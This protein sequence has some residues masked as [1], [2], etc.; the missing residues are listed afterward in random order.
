MLLN[1]SHE[2]EFLT[3]LHILLE[4]IV[5]FLCLC[6]WCTYK[7]RIYKEKEPTKLGTFLTWLSKR[8]IDAY[9]KSF[10]AETYS[11]CVA[12]SKCNCNVSGF[13]R[14]FNVLIKIYVTVIIIKAASLPTCLIMQ[15][16]GKV[17]AHQNWYAKWIALANVR[18][19]DGENNSN[20]N[21]INNNNKNP[22]KR[23][24]KW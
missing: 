4:K 15:I 11:H 8:K 13:I 10:F 14:M 2:C 6:A 21:S 12:T 19:C 3:T 23:N 16:N 5:F 18:W 7:S 9:I 22:P 1:R 24:E 17:N 20:T